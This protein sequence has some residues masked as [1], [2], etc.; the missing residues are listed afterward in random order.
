M[1]VEHH[2]FMVETAYDYYMVAST[3]SKGNF[4]AKLTIVA[5]SLEILFKSFN[6]KPTANLGTIDER[7]C[8]KQRN[9]DLDTLAKHLP[10]DISEY[11]GLTDE[12]FV[13]LGEHRNQFA[14]GRYYY[15]K[16]NSG[17][18]DS[19]LVNLAAK[20][21]VRTVELYRETGC[22]DLFIQSVQLDDIRAFFG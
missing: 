3:A 15:E 22:K 18:Y 11:L 21:L 14:L 16:E 2:P 7:Y 1:N 17:M 5:L 8:P 12:E 20:L 4:Q 9:H 19:S 13:V 10:D 6:S